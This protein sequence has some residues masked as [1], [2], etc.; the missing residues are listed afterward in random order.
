MSPPV[1]TYCGNVHPAESLDDWL[2][3]LVGPGA[4]I[5][6]SS[7]LAGRS[8]PL[9]V[10]WTAEVARSLATDASARERV[11]EILANTACHIATLNVFP[12]GGFHADVVKEAVYRPDWADD[13]RA[14]YTLDA[15]RAIAMLAAPGTTIPLSTLPLGFGT[16]HFARMASALR[17]TA[18][19][20][21]VI[22]AEYGVRCV[23]ALEPEPF[24][25]LE[26]ADAAARWLEE[27]VFRASTDEG[28]LRRHLGICVDLCH[29]AVVGEDAVV[30]LGELRARGIA[31]PKIQVSSCLELRDGAEIDRLLAFDEPRYLHQTVADGGALRA[32]DLGEVRARRSEFTRSERIRSHYHVPLFWD[33]DGPLGSTQR[34]VRRVLA[35]LRGDLPLLE[36][37][38]YTWNVLDRSFDPERD[39][40]RAIGRELDWVRDALAG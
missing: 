2:G 22:E 33:A 3:V 24:C 40:A 7:R 21:A 34:E 20:L 18:V 30:A 12:F 14:D 6:S 9:G 25:L 36:V 1:L 35:S 28:V 5:A 38:T 15:A 8:F 11:R 4:Q 32:R 23:L 27:R 16:G 13:R 37:E 10:W 26:R 29:L 17:A 39:L 31:V 19:Q